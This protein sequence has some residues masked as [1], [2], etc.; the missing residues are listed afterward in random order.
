MNSKLGLNQ[1]AMSAE[2]MSAISILKWRLEGGGLK[3][4]GL[5]WMVTMLQA[6]V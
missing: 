6:G 3:F 5:L 1:G 2:S 4:S